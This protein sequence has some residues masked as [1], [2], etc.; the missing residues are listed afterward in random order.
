MDLE[1]GVQQETGKS[2]PRVICQDASLQGEGPPVLVGTGSPQEDETDASL[3]LNML[4]KCLDGEFGV[5]QK[6][7]TNKKDQLIKRNCK[8][9]FL[10]L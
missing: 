9:G 1:G 3:C 2:I 7:K 10:A 6:T 8:H 4:R 5:E